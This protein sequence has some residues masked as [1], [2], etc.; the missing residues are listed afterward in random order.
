[1]RRRFPGVKP[2]MTR[3]WRPGGG[4]RRL[5]RRADGVG[6]DLHAAVRPATYGYRDSLTLEPVGCNALAALSSARGRTGVRRSG[7]P[8]FLSD[9]WVPR[10]G[11]GGCPFVPPA[12]MSGPLPEDLM[13]DEDGEGFGGTGRRCPRRGRCRRRSRFAPGYTCR[14]SLPR[15]EPTGTDAE[16]GAEEGAP[17]GRGGADGGGRRSRWRRRGPE[18]APEEAPMERERRT[19]DMDA[20]LGG[21]GEELLAKLRNGQRSTTPSSSTLG[22]VGSW[23]DTGS[24]TGDRIDERRE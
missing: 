3:A 18:A 16:P 24:N 22:C 10:R 7:H 20:E 6:E 1:M 9:E 2:T 17:G 12:L 8:R 21:R 14:A 11:R 19:R 15:G 4:L 13:T 23:C 5:R